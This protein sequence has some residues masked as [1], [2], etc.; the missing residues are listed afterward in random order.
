MVKSK[1]K[2]ATQSLWILAP[3]SQCSKLAKNNATNV[4]QSQFVNVMKSTIMLPTDVTN[5]QL[6]NFQVTLPR[7]KM[8]HVKYILSPVM[9]LQKFS[10]I[11][12]TATLAENVHWVKNSLEIFAKRSQLA[13]AI[14][15][16]TPSPTNAKIALKALLLIHQE[17]AA[18]FA[19]KL[20]WIAIMKERFSWIKN[21][22]TNVKPAQLQHILLET[23]ARLLLSQSALV[24]NST[25][26]WLDN[27]KTANKVGLQ[28]IPN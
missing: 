13:S 28:E 19:N 17:A 22:A 11:K 3:R 16:T 5:A 27:V 24:L 14:N 1:V 7:N 8:E 18:Q 4:F 26:N 23:H 6:V 21:N 10:L 15:S 20:S 2:N 12:R 25:T 9:D